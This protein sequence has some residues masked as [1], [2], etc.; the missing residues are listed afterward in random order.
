MPDEDTSLTDGAGRAERTS[1]GVV[2][3]DSELTCRYV[4][5]GA[6]QILGA[7]ATEL[8]GGS[9]TE[10]FHGVAGPVIRERIERAL[11]TGQ[12][13]RFEWTNSQGGGDV[14]VRIYPGTDG[15]TLSFVAEPD[16]GA[17]GC[18]PGKLIETAPVGIV[19]LDATG[20][21]EWA[22]RRAEEMV[23]L[24]H[25]E[26]EG[27]TYTHPEWEIWD[28][29][30]R[31]ISAAEH[32]V[33]RVLA[34][35]ETVTRFTHGITLPNGSTR[36]LSSNVAPVL[37][38]GDTVEQVVVAL[39]DVTALKRLEQLTGTFQPV[40]QLLGDAASRA[41][42]EQDICEV[43]TD[44][45]EYD[46]AAIGEC[47][48][49]PALLEPHA[50]SGREAAVDALEAVDFPLLTGHPGETAVATREVTVVETPRDNQGGER[51]RERLSDEDFESVAV[52]PLIHA[53]RVYGVL[54]LYTRRIDA[55]GTLERTLLQ[56]LGKQIGKVIHA[57]ETDKLLHS[58]AVVELTFRSTDRDSFLV[59]ASE[60]LGCSLALKN[61][62][63]DSDGALVHYVSV[64]GTP[65]SAV[66]EAVS[67]REGVL[68]TRTVHD[69]EDGTGGI[70]EV[71]TRG[72]SLV[73][74]LVNL[75][76]VVTAA[77]VSEGEA[78]VICKIPVGR[79]V[80]ALVDSLLESFPE[81]ELVAKR[82]VENRQENAAWPSDR[83]LADVFDTELS[84]RQRQVLRT[85][86]YGGYF[87]SPRRS[88]AS[89]IAEALSLSQ[90]TVSYHLRNAQ[91][92]LFRRMFEQL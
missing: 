24:E 14:G 83:V 90:S 4:D 22:N 21:I 17:G 78:S 74:T 8:V 63:P 87:Q 68:E 37:G 51:V 62:V 91:D 76:A 16:I 80:T 11:D 13:G 58:N 12:P 35:A 38:E 82:E 64:E 84:D 15:V 29:S 66:G 86:V 10:T 18:R 71:I 59:S 72:E 54:G 60:A 26:I 31:K 34:T 20:E 28:E 36:W 81:T 33:S 53:Q 5:S 70:I 61:T 49:G 89:D 32:P 9:I 77:T 73:Q 75:D 1:S 2:V 42:T 44:T 56:S 92:T 55:F 50:T 40:H 69:R 7:S 88:S 43:L 6:E 41:G 39:E 67:E 30:G 23:G 48:A 45:R 65:A 79:D 19:V 52:V 85:A 25:S 3:F 47:T 27:R 46:V 57:I